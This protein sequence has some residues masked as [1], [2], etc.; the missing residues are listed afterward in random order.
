MKPWLIL[1]I[2]LI[3]GC[4][5][6][7]YVVPDW[8]TVERD[9]TQAAVDPDALPELCDID[10]ATGA[11]S[12]ECWQA[13]VRYVE[14][15]ETNTEVAALMAEALRKSDAAYD[16]LIAAGKLEQ[17]LAQIRQDLLEDERR[18]HRMDNWFYRGI[19]ALGLIGVAL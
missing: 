10:G 19:I 11:W 13:F 7:R 9:T 15:A 6:D 4:A 8:N 12:L 18:A 14:I 2:V 16:Y 1:L 5:T 3:S 17:Q